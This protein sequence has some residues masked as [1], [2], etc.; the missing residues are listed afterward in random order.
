MTPTIDDRK[1]VRKATSR[2]LH[3]VTPSSLGRPL[4]GEDSLDAEIGSYTEHLD[5]N[6]EWCREVFGQSG[7]TGKACEHCLALYPSLLWNRPKRLHDCL[8]LQAILSVT[9]YPQT[10]REEFKVSAFCVSDDFVMDPEP[11][12]VGQRVIYGKVA[13]TLMA[14]ITPKPLGKR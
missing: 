6:G 8:S 12:V 14:R 13:L 3:L 2:I 1:T 4:C 11:S 9:P 5:D 10:I 7:K